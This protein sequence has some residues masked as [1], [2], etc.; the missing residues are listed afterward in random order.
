MHVAKPE[1][2]ELPDGWDEV[3]SKSTGKR[4]Y[5]NEQR[6]LTQ[7]T[8]PGVVP[9]PSNSGDA[10][11][12]NGDSTPSKK[13]ASSPLLPAGWEVATSPRSGKLFFHNERMGVTQSERPVTDGSNVNRTPARSPRVKAT[14]VPRTVVGG[15]EAKSDLRDGSGETMLELLRQEVKAH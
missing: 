11:D 3:V 5:H 12:H 9:V 10:V 2:R 15:G 14:L 13:P 1:G 8:H 7:A 6:G 4:L